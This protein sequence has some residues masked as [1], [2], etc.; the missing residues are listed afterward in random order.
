MSPWRS[1]GL[2][3]SAVGFAARAAGFAARAGRFVAGRFIAAFFIL[4]A[5]FI[6]GMESSCPETGSRGRNRARRRPPRHGDDGAMLSSRL[7]PYTREGTPFARRIIIMS[8]P[9]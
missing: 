5:D 4:P 7:G 8:C 2:A 3:P 1:A 9:R 6:V